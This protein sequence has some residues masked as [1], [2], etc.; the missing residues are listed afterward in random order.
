MGFS[1]GIME[2]P[3]LSFIFLCMLF[4]APSCSRYYTPPSVPRLTD[5]VP[6][7][8]TDQ[9]FAKIFGASNIQLRN[10]GSSVDLTLDKVSGAGLVSRNK[11]HYGFF[12]AS[13]KLPSG[14]T[15]GVV[16]A[17]YLSNADVYPH[18]HDEIDIELLGHDKRKD[19]VIQTNIYANGSVK[20]GREEKF[21]LWFDPSLKYHD[22]TIIW[23]NY[24]TVF[25]V[26]NVP[27]RELRNSEV[28]YPS[29]PMSVFVTIWDGSEWAT[30]GG[31]YPVDYKHAP[32]TASFEEMEINGGILTPK[33]TVPSSSKANVSGPD[34]A[35]GPEFIKL[36]Q[37]QVDA[38]D[39]ARRKL[40]FYSYCKDTSRYKVLP[41]ECK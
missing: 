4:V 27:V 6:R 28:F 34:T 19:W 39:W 40:M 17:F 41:P 33:A 25:L 2:L 38:M 26:D 36:S 8:S 5:L 3:L 22:Y 7:V 31:K 30:H 16:V 9:C 32:Y 29:K 13:I 35:E 21:Y 14:L 20:T 11:Y 10:N 12:S 15:S 23:N 37:Q 18:S 24:H 1:R